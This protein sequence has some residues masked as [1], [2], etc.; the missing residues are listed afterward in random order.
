MKLK[1]FLKHVLNNNKEMHF[2]YIILGV[3]LD[4]EVETPRIQCMSHLFSWH[5]RS[6]KVHGNCQSG[7]WHGVQ[8][9]ALNR[10]CVAAAGA[11]MWCD[12]FQDPKRGLC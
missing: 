1:I 11:S 10:H 7:L 12:R 8:E 3:E 5:L 4:S 6:S 2:V 9:A